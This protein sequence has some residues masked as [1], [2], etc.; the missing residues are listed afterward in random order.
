MANDD[1]FEAPDY[2]RQRDAIYDLSGKSEGQQI[3][4]RAFGQAP[5]PEVEDLLG[6]ELSDGRPMSAFH[7]V[8]ENLQLRLGVHVSS[9]SQQQIATFLR[10]IGPLR[11]GPNQDLAVEHGV[12]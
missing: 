4:C 6:I 2:R 12:R 9:L 1:V 7:V 8:R 3:A 11:P 5:T 10:R